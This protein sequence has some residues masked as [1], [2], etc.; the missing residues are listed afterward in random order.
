M[1]FLCV[2]RLHKRTEYSIFYKLACS[3][4]EDANQ[5]DQ[6]SLFGSKRAGSFATNRVRLEE[7]DQ[8]ARMRRLIIVFALRTAL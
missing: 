5:S 2:P 3:P 1:H 7:S 6:S 4:R 8:T